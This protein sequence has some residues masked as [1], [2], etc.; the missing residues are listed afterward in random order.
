MPLPETVA[1]RY[2][3]EAAEYLSV[4][5]VVRQTFRLDELLDMVL[6]VTG[7]D[8]ARVAQILRA[9]SV[10]Y[11]AYRYWWNGIET[12][13]ADLRAALARFPDRDPARTFHAAEC[14]A[15]LFESGAA[16]APSLL[17][18][19]RPEASATK[20]F[21]RKSF[22]DVLMALASESAPAYED[23][24]Y[25]RRGDLFRLR[26]TGAQAARLAQDA[27]KLASRALRI[28]LAAAPRLDRL[29]FVCPR[30]R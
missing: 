3:E 25:E 2:T 13:E 7:K 20:L 22:W 24:S 21:S 27:G 19:T 1:L 10:V 23:Y 15:V 14:A 8:A 4:R 11:H 9:G 12:S 18:I 5:P 6:R 26:L 29:L 28:R 16:P 17:E 30:P